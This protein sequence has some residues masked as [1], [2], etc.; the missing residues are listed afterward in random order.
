[1]LQEGDRQFV[2]NTSHRMNNSERWMNIQSTYTSAAIVTRSLNTEFNIVYFVGEFNFSYFVLDVTTDCCN[3]TSAVKRVCKIFYRETLYVAWVC[4]Y[5]K[6]FCW[7]NIYCAEFMR[8]NKSE[9][10]EKA[11][12]TNVYDFPAV[13]C[14]EIIFQKRYSKHDLAELLIA[15]ILCKGTYTTKIPKLPIKCE[16]FS[17]IISVDRIILVRNFFIFF[18]SF[19][20]ITLRKITYVRISYFPALK[21]SLS[22]CFSRS[23]DQFFLKLTF[24]RKL[25]LSRFLSNI[26]LDRYSWL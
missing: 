12:R 21:H 1:M 25:I 26:V 15:D 23:R 11:S 4:I 8:E 7:L 2:L 9:G 22:S 20:A 18:L 6:R 24:S 14:R 5:T 10:G 19:R 17:H 16:L 13:L 3:K